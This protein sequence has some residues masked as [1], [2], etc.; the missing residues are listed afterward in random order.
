MRKNV[1]SIREQ[2]PE[3]EL[4]SECGKVSLLQATLEGDAEQTT[5]S[6]AL[7]DLELSPGSQYSVKCPN[8]GSK[9]I[10][11]KKLSVSL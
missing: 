7:H 5:S 6:S 3:K 4:H 10:F 9:G 1:T 8:L 11:A 2:G